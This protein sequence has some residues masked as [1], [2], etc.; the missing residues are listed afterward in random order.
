MPRHRVESVRKEIDGT[1]VASCRRA[2]ARATSAPT[3]AGTPRHDCSPVPQEVE[4]DATRARRDAFVGT[5]GQGRV[6]R[7]RGRRRSRAL[8][9]DASRFTREFEQQVAWLAASSKTATAELMRID[10]ASVGGA[11]QAR[12]R[13]ARRRGRDR[14][15]GLGRIGVRRD[16]VQEGPHKTVGGRDHDANRVVWCAKGHGKAVLKPFFEQLGEDQRP[17][18]RW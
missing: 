8:G 11:M 2:R 16:F 13:R 15:D 9:R 1:I 17:A 10:W 5:P 4:D 12:L 6:P 18:C 7:A 14:F 3:A